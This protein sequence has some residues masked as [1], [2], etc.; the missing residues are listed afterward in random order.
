MQHKPFDSDINHER[1]RSPV[2]AL[3]R[4]HDRRVSQFSPRCQKAIK[5]YSSSTRT[6]GYIPQA[7]AASFDV[8][9]LDTPPTSVSTSEPDSLSPPALFP[10]G[11]ASVSSSPRRFLSA[12]PAASVL[13]AA[14]VSSSAD[15]VDTFWF[16]YAEWSFLS[17]LFS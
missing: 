4:L 7:L 16:S 15:I 10:P 12:G 6:C 3:Q 11:D 2:L 14:F 9:Y 8:D 1:W 17:P 13:L 5:A